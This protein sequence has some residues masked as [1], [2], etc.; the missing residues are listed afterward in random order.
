MFL[1]STRNVS[2]A[3][4]IVSRVHA[5]VSRDYAIVSRAHAKVFIFLFFANV[6]LGAPY[7]ATQQERFHLLQVCLYHEMF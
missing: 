1:V 7:S 3:H 2:R 6:P 4:G 5:K